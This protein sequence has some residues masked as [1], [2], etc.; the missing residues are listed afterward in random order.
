MMIG[1]DG[2]WVLA[3]KYF[4]LK[5]ISDSGITQRHVKIE[6]YDV[7]TVG[8]IYCR[9]RFQGVGTGYLKVSP[10]ARTIRLMSQA[11][12]GTLDLGP[13]HISDIN[14]EVPVDSCL[15]ELELFSFREIHH[16]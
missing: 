16:D 11:E 7:K 15:K 10:S 1:R 8:P 4:F 12:E 3:E 14:I 2:R 5:I 6:N 9:Y 13:I